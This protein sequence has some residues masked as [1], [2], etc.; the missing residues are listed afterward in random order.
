MMYYSEYCRVREEIV[1]S[2]HLQNVYTALSSTDR[3]NT[4]YGAKCVNKE[5]VFLEEL[6]K[7]LSVEDNVHQGSTIIYC[8]SVRMVEKVQLC[9]RLLAVQRLDI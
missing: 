4:F 8:T 9:L 3:P 5:S 1:H 2:L 6:V 7:L